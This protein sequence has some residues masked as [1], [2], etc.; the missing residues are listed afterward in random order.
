MPLFLS[1]L[2]SG[3][4]FNLLSALINAKTDAFTISVSAPCPLYTVLFLEI[5]TV[6]S[7]WASVPDVILFTE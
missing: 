5:L 3:F 6:T 1:T 7:P 4:S 2:D